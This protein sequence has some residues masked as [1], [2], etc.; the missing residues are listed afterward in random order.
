MRAPRTRPIYVAEVASI[1]GMLA[2][3]IALIVA[4]WEPLE[5]PPSR[6]GRASVIEQEQT[7]DSGSG[8]ESGKENKRERR[9]RRSR[10]QNERVAPMT[11]TPIP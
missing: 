8:S 4:T 1:V 6:A 3:P 10:D 2:I 11:A 5:P 7:S 9:S